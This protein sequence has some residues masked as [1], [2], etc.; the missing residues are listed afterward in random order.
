MNEGVEKYVKMQR[1]A[2]E[3]FDK[4]LEWHKYNIIVRPEGDYAFTNE[5]G[6]VEYDLL[7]GKTD[8][9]THTA[10]DFG[11]GIGR[12]MSIWHNKF[13]KIDGV[14]ISASCLKY[15]SEL[16]ESKNI[17]NNKLFLCNGYDLANISSDAYDV[18]YSILVLEHICVHE[19][20]NNYFKEFYRVLK[21]SGTISITMKGGI[22]YNINNPNWKDWYE[23][24]Y[25][26]QETNG[27]CDVVIKQPFDVVFDL[28]NIGFH[29]I[30][31]AFLKLLKSAKH[32]AGHQYIVII[33]AQK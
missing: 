1:K 23:N 22:E 21:N 33:R 20:R 7:F 26:A 10:L 4:D 32:I 19:I 2:Y 30:E 16:L 31:L 6:E 18:V 5:H 25:D 28:E 9:T 17:T 15:A 13:L 27:S 29:K 11:C 3:K 24:F 12:L 8:H 14:D